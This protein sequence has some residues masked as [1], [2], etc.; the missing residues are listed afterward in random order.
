MAAM[1]AKQHE[2]IIGQISGRRNVR[3]AFRLGPSPEVELLERVKVLET[4]AEL[5][6]AFPDRT[7]RFLAQVGL[8]A[9]G[10]VIGAQATA[11]DDYVWKYD[12]NYKWVDMV[13]DSL[14]I[15]FKLMRILPQ[16][17]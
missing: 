14:C 17:F 2:M 8:L 10:W 9:L 13:E 3:R 11:L 16:F 5:Q 12:E 7:M 15:A 6:W 4:A 1:S